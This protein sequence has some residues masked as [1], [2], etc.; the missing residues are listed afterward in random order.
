MK[1]MY[2]I[3][4]NYERNNIKA[5]AYL[6]KFHSNKK[7]LKMDRKDILAFLINQR[8]TILCQTCSCEHEFT[9]KNNMVKLTDTSM[10]NETIAERS[11]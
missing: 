4:Y 3:S 11:N 5:L 2:H 1:L 7:F 6:S 10:Q 8:I 9:D